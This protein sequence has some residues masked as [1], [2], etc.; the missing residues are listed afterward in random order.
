MIVKTGKAEWWAVV[1]VGAPY[2]ENETGEIVSRHRSYCAAFIAWRKLQ[3]RPRYYGKNSQIVRIGAD[4][5]VI[6][7]FGY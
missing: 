7:K 4:G 5:N 3:S 1:Y 6:E 2:G